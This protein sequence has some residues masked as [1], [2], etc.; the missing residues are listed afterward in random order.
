[1][2]VTDRLSGVPEGSRLPTLFM[3]APTK[4]PILLLPEN[5]C[6]LLSDMVAAQR[7]VVGSPAM[8]RETLE[9]FMDIGQMPLFMQRLEKARPVLSYSNDVALFLGTIS[10]TPADAVLWAYSLFELTRTSQEGETPWVLD[11]T[12]LK[13]RFDQGVPSANARESLWTLQKQKGASQSNWLDTD[14]AW[15]VA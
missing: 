3:F 6:V 4:T 2:V 11:V 10:S 12:K 9:D 1:M 15:L 13:E 8:I 5:A 14:A 7:E